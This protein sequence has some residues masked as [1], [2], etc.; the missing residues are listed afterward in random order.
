MLMLPPSAD[1]AIVISGSG[2]NAIA[3]AKF[4][5]VAGG[6]LF[7]QL[8]CCSLLMGEL[9]LNGCCLVGHVSEL[10]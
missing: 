7:F 10:L 3:I 1:V 6:L 4:H 2:I 8:S 9:A 5:G